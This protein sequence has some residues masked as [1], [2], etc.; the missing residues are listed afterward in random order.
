MPTSAAPA[1]EATDLAR[2]APRRERSDV[3]PE[4][5]SRRTADGARPPRIVSTHLCVSRGRAGQAGR[6]R[7]RGI[8]PQ[9]VIRL[10]ELISSYRPISLSYHPYKYRIIRRV[11]RERVMKA[12]EIEMEQ[13]T[14]CEQ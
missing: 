14:R 10:T 2:G 7:T 4:S 11:L 9:V 1:Q 13:L 12:L 5:D 6:A 3:S 8:W